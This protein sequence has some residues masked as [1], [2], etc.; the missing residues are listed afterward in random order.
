[1][2]RHLI[3]GR[4]GST[5]VT[6]IPLAK[7]EIFS[8]LNL[9]D[10]RGK[11]NYG[12][13]DAL[14]YLAKIGISPTEI[15]VDILVLAAHVQ[16]ADTHISRNTESQD[17][18]T[19]EIRLVVPVS[20]PQIWN[21]TISILKR[22]LN[23]L[24]GDIWSV[25]FRPRP[26]P[27][28]KMVPIASPLLTGTPYN[29]LSLFSGGLDSLVG[30]IDFLEDGKNPLF[31]SH[32]GEGSVSNVQ[33]ECF[34]ILKNRF[35]RSEMDRLRI[36]MTFPNL[37]IKDSESEKTTRAR[38]FL[39]FSMGI[40]AGTGFDSHFVLQVPEN[41]L[42]A[43]NVPLDPLR[44]GSNSTR[45]T[46]PFYI[47][48]WNELLQILQI[49]GRLQNPYWNKTK[50]EMIL[51]CSNQKLLKELVSKT[52]SCSSP[53]KGRWQGLGSQHCGYCLPCVIRRA[54]IERG[55]GSGCDT[56]KYSTKNLNRKTLSTLKAEGQLIRSL[57]FAINRLGANLNRAKI[58]I[59]SSGSLSDESFDRQ[60][61][62]ANV[63]LRGME[64]VQSFLKGV[65][66]KPE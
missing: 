52:I 40:F 18:W 57:Q 58:L 32:A 7:N 35:S 48:R 23:F 65:K 51:E 1:M 2:K 3:S 46:H 34:E 24:T 30:A 6:S 13:D 8:Q 14:N 33:H 47:A 31:I 62:L 44:L 39:F 53:T 41:G 38:S 45:T 36:W 54:A 61:E 42:I 16:A 56:T 4:F 5:D 20:N 26:T 19:R 64:E 25:S 50:G 60:A 59:N 10:S 49:N 28:M 37:H 15:G 55:F 43:L 22:M 66:T 17:C 11:L 63:Y 27:L 29:C 12:M 9:V 21:N